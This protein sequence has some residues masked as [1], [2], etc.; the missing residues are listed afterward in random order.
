MR[1]RGFLLAAGATAMLPLGIAAEPIRQRQEARPFRLGVT[2]WPPDVTTEAVAMTDAFIASNCDM[3]APMMLGGVPWTEA[4]S[5]AEFST[6]ANAAL[7]YRPPRGHKLFVSIGAL[8]MGRARLAS[9]WG[10]KDNM[11][12][13]GPFRDLPFDAPQI[14]EAHTN[15]ALRVVAAMRPDWFAIGI[16]ANILLS[17]DPRAWPAY[18]ALHRRVYEAVKA[19]YPRLK[20]C[21]T[22][23]ALHYLGHARGSDTTL[24]RR[25]LKELL[26][27]SD[28]VAFSVYPHMS[29]SVP[30]PLPADFFDFAR[31]LSTAAGGKP[32]AI[33]ESGYTS[34]DVWVG[35]IPLFG[36]PEDQARHMTL[37]LEAAQR[38]RYEF[39][40]N[41]AATD[42]EKLSA[43][44][45]GEVGTLSRIWMHTGLQASDAT[46]KPALAVWRNALARPLGNA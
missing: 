11:P 3:V 13:P 23:D 38:D 25:E 20:V 8:D 39:V 4:L 24:Q 42:F 18:K 32:I 16:E 17:N 37:L 22:I 35:L 44:L 31:E 19:R 9:Y 41:Y 43:R 12:L 34:R 27:F 10:E 26:A 36:S 7:A 15:F 14:S 6:D 2:R 46:A 40:V 1:R 21:F 28:L 45:S 30:R 5:G 29:W 33:S